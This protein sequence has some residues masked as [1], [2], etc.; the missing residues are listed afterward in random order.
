MKLTMH[1]NKPKRNIFGLTGQQR[2]QLFRPL[3]CCTVS[4]T[5]ILCS[6]CNAST[7]H[8]WCNHCQIAFRGQKLQSFLFWSGICR[9]LETSPSQNARHSV[10]DRPVPRENFSQIHSAVLEETHPRQTDR[11]TQL[12][13]NIKPWGNNK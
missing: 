4:I 10:W 9:S 2:W 13:G 7:Y 12:T 1:K 3:H 6:N 8:F 11:K 5:L